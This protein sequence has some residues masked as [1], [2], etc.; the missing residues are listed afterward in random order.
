[1]RRTVKDMEVRLVSS[2]QLLPDPLGVFRDG[3]VD[4][5]GLLSQVSFSARTV[6]QLP[7]THPAQRSISFYGLFLPACPRAQQPAADK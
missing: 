6:A 7:R 5:A 1:M 4:T 2:L 3:D